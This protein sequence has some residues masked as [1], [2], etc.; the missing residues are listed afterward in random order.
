MLEQF[1]RNALRV[2][3]VAARV[4]SLKLEIEGVV[5]SVVSGYD[6]QVGCKL[7][8]RE[9]FWSEVD[10]VMQSYPQR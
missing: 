8:E 9:E 10:E 1:I 7:E 3:R 4:M 6:P 2:K 5:F